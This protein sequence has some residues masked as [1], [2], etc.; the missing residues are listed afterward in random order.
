MTRKE[1]IIKIKKIIKS[2]WAAFFP[3][4]KDCKEIFGVGDAHGIWNPGEANS[5]LVNST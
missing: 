3:S 4:S 5:L 2:F 1:K